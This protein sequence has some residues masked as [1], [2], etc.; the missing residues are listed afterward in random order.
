M[1]DALTLTEHGHS[2]NER[3]AD[4]AAFV[5]HLVV[6]EAKGRHTR[7]HVGAIA[8]GIPGLR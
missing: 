8:L 5:S 6:S 7:E 3:L 1:S 4:L 2:F